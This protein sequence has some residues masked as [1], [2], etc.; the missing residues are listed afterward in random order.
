M[1]LALGCSVI[2]SMHHPGST[3]AH[4]NNCMHFVGSRGDQP[5]HLAS[6]YHLHQKDIVQLRLMLVCW[7]RR[8]GYQW[9]QAINMA[10]SSALAASPRPTR[11]PSLLHSAY[12]DTALALFPGGMNMHGQST[13]CLLGSALCLYLGQAHSQ[14]YAAIRHTHS[15]CTSNMSAIESHHCSQTLFQLLRCIP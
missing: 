9:P 15:H 10:A 1:R 3:I 8:T 2:G 6:H 12:P 14:P 7:T 5:P 13:T 11:A 4:N